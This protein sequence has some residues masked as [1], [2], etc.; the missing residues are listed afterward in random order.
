MISSRQIKA[1]RA[2]LGWTQGDLAHATGLHVNGVNKIE[3]GGS[4]PRSSTLERVQSVC[5]A[6]GI[7]FRGQ[8]GVELKEDIFETKRFEGPD[9]IR[10]H[11]DDILAVVRGPGDEVLNCGIDEEIFNVNYMKQNERY[12]R[13]MKKTGFRERYLMSRANPVFTNPDR[14]VHRRLPEKILGTVAYVVYGDRV[15]FLHWE[16]QETLIIRNKSLAATFRGQFE[17][18]W[19]QAKPLE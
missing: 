6:A 10:H 2:L 9:F 16:T 19:S 17:G 14:N 5:E 4:E 8:R 7:R 12:Y 1:A 15:A 3:N 13:H 11:I 18:L